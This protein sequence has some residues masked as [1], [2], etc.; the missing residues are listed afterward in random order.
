MKIEY[1]DFMCCPSCNS[2]LRIESESVENDRIKEGT[3][4]CLSCNKEYIVKN[5]IPR[6]I[7]T[8]E[9][10]DSFG[11]Q[12]NAFANVQLDDKNTS[13]SSLRF[14]SE[15]GWD[16]KKLSGKSVIEIGSGAG[17]FV[18]VVSNRKAELVVGIDV[19]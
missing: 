2:D 12:W 19:T 14:D 18:D 1:L 6:F 10:A 16:E 8:K 4:V 9:Y 3:L 15:I 7:E 5:F 11:S 13:E 17:R